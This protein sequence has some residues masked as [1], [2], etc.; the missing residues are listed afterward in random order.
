[1]GIDTFDSVNIAELEN[2][3]KHLKLVQYLT[4]AMNSAKNY[5]ELLELMIDQCIELTSAVSGSIMLKDEQSQLLR[6]EVFRGIDPEIIKD[7]EIPIGYGV[8]GLVMQE[9]SPKLVN[10]VTLEPKYITVRQDIRSELVV[11]LNIN[12]VVM[13]VV[14]VDSDKKDAFSE[15]DLELLQTIS[16]QAAQILSKTMLTQALERKIMM[17]DI[18]IDIASEVEKTIE[19]RDVFDNIMNHLTTSF[20]ITRGMLVLFENVDLNTLSVVSAYNLTEEEISRGVY[21]VGE[22]IIG[23]VVETG[24]AISI[25]DIHKNEQFLNRMQIKR[26]KNVPI[27]FI[28]IPLKVEGVVSGVLAVEKPFENAS[29]LK[30]EE[31]IIYLIGNMISNKVNAYQKIMEERM[32]LLEENIQLRKELFDNYQFS[33]II[34]KNQKMQEVFEL[35]KMVADSNSTILILGE[36]GT[37][38]ELVARS[39]H[40]NSARKDKPFISVN[41]AAIPENLLE[42]ELFG[43]KKGS[44]TGALTDK[45][46]KFLIANE[47]T[48]FLDEIGDMPLFLQAKLLRAI[49]EK[50]IEPI[51]SEEKIT[52]NI[53]IISATNQNLEKLVHE[54]KF[55]KDL[56]YRLNV[57]EMHIPSLKERKDDIPLLVS[58]FIKKYSEANKREVSRISQ[59]ALRILQS[60]SWPGNVRE[61][62]NVIE[63][64]VIL[65]RGNRIEITNLPSFLTENEEEVTDVNIGKWIESSIRHGGVD[66]NFYNTIISRIEKEVITKAL[67]YNKRNKVKTSEF[68]GIN[69][70]TLRSKMSEYEINI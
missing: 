4:G 46:G 3:I 20:N 5:K 33:N 32:T 38:K 54:G 27:S 63:R 68:L 59:E 17:R 51:G 62:E 24:K 9:G 15:Q 69:R 60:Y 21:K 12:G 28:A 7:M 52:V 65:S 36:S 58:H 30:D 37:G 45:R 34:G 8:T 2:Q 14:S 22:G 44:F 25:P 10:D 11:P 39:I 35:V 56:Y 55:R 67:I 1:M 43:F 57:I 26:D 47:G 16:N 6:F 66:G 49:Q 19:L 64:A 61:L 48:L 29:V 70:N 53:R 23:R 42:S 31:D 40:Y 50:E 13:G 18:L 41:C